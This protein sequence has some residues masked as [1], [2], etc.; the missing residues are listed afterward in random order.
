MSSYQDVSTYDLDYRCESK[1]HIFEQYSPRYT[2]LHSHSPRC[3]HQAQ[4]LN[5]DV[6]VVSCLPSR[7]FRSCDLEILETFVMEL[8]DHQMIRHRRRN[9]HLIHHLCNSPH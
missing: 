4:S 2:P 5:L 3:H 6:D 8:E 9:P 7:P 1:Q